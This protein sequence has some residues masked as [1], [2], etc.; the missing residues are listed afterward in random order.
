MDQMEVKKK[1]FL[2][3]VLAYFYPHTMPPEIPDGMDQYVDGAMGTDVTIQ[4]GFKDFIKLF[5][6]GRVLIVQTRMKVDAVVSRIFSLSNIDVPPPFSIIQ[7]QIKIAKA[8][9]KEEENSQE[10]EHS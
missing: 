1:T 5:F 4:L 7:H 10:K 2:E 3:R 9:Q 6:N 8:K